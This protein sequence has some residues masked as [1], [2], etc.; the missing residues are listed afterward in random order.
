MYRGLYIYFILKY[1]TT[2][3]VYPCKAET[4]TEQNLNFLEPEKSV[5]QKNQ[6]PA[7]PSSTAEQEKEVDIPI[8]IVEDIPPSA[9]ATDSQNC[10]TQPNTVQKIIIPT[11]T[12]LTSA[13]YKPEIPTDKPKGPSPTR[14]LPSR[15]ENRKSSIPSAA[16]ELGIRTSP[17]KS[18]G[19]GKH[20]IQ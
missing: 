10:A 16:S 20:V 13:T 18:I 17:D 4:Q 8:V 19:E 7:V 11:E 2:L 14:L 3:I 12:I 15:S 1:I 5:Q 9:V 6:V